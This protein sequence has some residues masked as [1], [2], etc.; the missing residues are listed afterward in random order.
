VRRDPAHDG[1]VLGIPGRVHLAVEQRDR[2]RVEC[3]VDR[4][5]RFEDEERV[6]GDRSVAVVGVD[7][8]HGLRGPDDRGSRLAVLDRQ[9]F[10][11][12]DLGPGQPDQHRRQLRESA[13][14]RL[15]ADALRA[16]PGVVE[17]EDVLLGGGILG[18]DRRGR[19]LHF[20]T[21]LALQELE[22]H[23]TSNGSMPVILAARGHRPPPGDRR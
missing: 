8:L 20:G 5:N 13:R 10:D 1:A 9:G 22:R 6:T 14:S 18:H 19:Q 2:E 17:L 21:A 15:E 12:L 16:L 23:G 11:D 4:V 3:Q 7:P